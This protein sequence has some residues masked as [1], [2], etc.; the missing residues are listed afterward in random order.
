MKRTVTLVLL[1]LFSI[2][3]FSQVEL[4]Y[5]AT[6]KAQA[7]GMSIK[8]LSPESAQFLSLY[9]QADTLKSRSARKAAQM[10]LRERYGVQRGRVSAI[11]ELAEGH[12]PQELR[13]YG[14]S[15]GCKAGNLLTVTIPVK[16]FAELAE[17]GICK[18]ID[19]GYKF[20][21]LMDNVR[22]N[23]GIDQIHAGLNLP[24]GYDGSGVVVGIIVHGFEY[25]HPS[26]YDSTGTV[27][28]VKRV[29][30][31]TDT[32]GTAP[33]GFD[34]GSEYVTEAQ[35]LAA[36]TDD[37]SATH[38]NHVAGI[39][40]RCGAPSGDGAAYKGIAPGADIVLVPS[41]K[42]GP[43]V[44][45]AIHY[46]YNYAQSVGKPCVI[47]MSF[48]NIKGPHDGT[49]TYERM[50]T[51]FA[52]QHPDS[53][54]FVCSAGNNAG[55]NIH[56]MKQFS[57]TDTLM[58][59]Q[60]KKDYLPASDPDGW[61]EIWGN[62]SYRLG[63]TLIDPDNQT[64]ED[65]TSFFTTGADTLIET[66]LV[67]SN[68]DS[69]RCKFVF[70]ERNSYNHAYHTGI[71]VE[72]ESVV[73]SSKELI[74]TVI[75]DTAAS[76]HAWCGQFIFAHS[77]SVAGTIGGNDQCTLSGFGSHTDAA[78]SVGSYVT[79]RS[80]TTYTGEYFDE[81]AAAMAGI[82]DFSSKGPTRDGRVKPDITAPG[83]VTVAAYNRYAEEPTGYAIY[84]TI[85]WN[86]HTDQFG[87]MAGTS[88]AAPVVTGIIA[89]WMQHNPSLGTDSLRALV[90]AT[91]RNDCFTGHV[92]NNPSNVWG[93]GKVNAYGGLPVS[94]DMFLVNA[95][96][97]EDGYGTVTGGGVVMAGF[98][99]LTATPSSFSHFVQWDDGVTDNPRTVH[100]TCDTT[101]VA[102]FEL[103]DYEDCDTIR[104]YP[105]TAEFDDYLTCWKP[106]DA[107]G[108]GAGWKK[109]QNAVSSMALI[110][111]DE[112]CDDW[113]VSPAMEIN[114]PLEVRLS[115]KGEDVMGSQDCSLLLSTSGSDA[116]DFSTVLATYTNTVVEDF[117]MSAALNDYQGQVVRLA[118]RHHNV[119]GMGGMLKI[120]TFVVKPDT[121][122]SVT[123]HEM[124]NYTVLTNGLQLT[125]RGA[126][127][128]PLQIYDMMGRLLVHR[129][130]AD[131]TYQMPAPGVYI[132]RVDGFRP[133]K[134][135]VVR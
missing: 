99:T 42:T 90:H 6:P 48:G 125:V 97:E 129:R 68:H 60:L 57:A 107:D 101:F 100:V 49:D 25:C 12:T 103:I 63:L 22:G 79:R 122:I 123:T 40:A 30:C 86:G 19:V 71:V 112:I 119:T 69:L 46:I 24:H 108:D 35:M 105:W 53:V 127:G 88:M 133:Q 110:F 111:G 65:F 84:D 58:T 91:A 75:C 114:A 51:A 115:M 52:E 128:Q 34:Y 72:N 37:S 21:D 20:D 39:A 135:V 104:N 96:G 64:Q 10:Q 32:I 117:E 78:I 11:V 4:D 38:G 67:T 55:D 85:H 121:T 98:Y 82:S 1:L 43:T 92:A 118:L 17:S 50:L 5:S 16:R 15:V 109:S 2:A 27:L 106:V 130:S 3:G 26:F 134:V 77:S 47:N 9:R 13:A 120:N 131:G 74:L 124:R 87:T 18:C 33:S 54:A 7:K 56:L 81:S 102:L 83:Q 61:V 45:D 73:L 14:V 126:E 89:L 29:W 28:R 94:T 59:T 41:K 80:Y 8:G 132:L 44:L 113:L 116:A 95:F 76:L 66:Y 93:H 31:Q 70:S 36:F 62:G 23:L